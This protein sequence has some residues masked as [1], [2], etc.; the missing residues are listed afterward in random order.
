MVALRVASVAAGGDGVAREADGR[1]VFLPRT[2]PGDLV[3]AEIVEE[4][5]SYARG[6]VGEL[7]E[8]GPGRRPAPCPYYGACG[9]CQLQHLEAAAQRRAKREIVHDALERIGGVEVEVP[10]PEAH[11][12][13][14]GYRNRVTFLL[15]REEGATRAG[16]HRFDRPA[17]LLDVEA[18][19]L[20]EP[21]LGEAWSRLRAAWGSSAG[22]LPAGGE[23]RLTLRASVEG[24]IALVV[25]GGQDGRPGE[26]GRVTEAVPTLS[27]YHWRPRD[28]GR[29]RLAGGE[30]LEERWAGHR[31]RLRPEAFL[32][33]NR[34]VSDAMDRHLAAGLEPGPGRRLLDLY[35]GV[36]VR[37]FGWALAG[38]EVATCERSRD[39]V[40]T[41]REAAR[42]G[43][44]RVR[45]VR[46]RVERRLAE[47]L[48]AD[49]A[50]VNPP[51]SGL[52]RRAA[53]R[54]AG[55]A[56]RL[57]K[58][59]YVSCDPATLARDLTRLAPAWELDGVRTYD[60]FPQTAHVETIAWLR[61]AAR[62]SA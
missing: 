13:E 51:R 26:P 59:A 54:L 48:P 18:C 2:A 9:G 8:R 37:G 30:T 34:H 62:G 47:L 23:L 32:Q 39:A 25:H 7:L 16:Y 58:L 56:G 36:G 60:A 24:R 14:F 38:A 57:G 29:R 43:R 42:R 31:L 61:P 10:P 5:S 55:A 40:A 17:E 35:A 20:A 1:V 50:V 33:V 49:G 27:A 6:R 46:G 11:G 15:R 52:S 44:A 3:R 12:P 45:I 53:E 4:R 19:P 21:A 28:G 22:A 41:A